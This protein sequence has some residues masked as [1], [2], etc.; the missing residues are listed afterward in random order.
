MLP[1]SPARMGDVQERCNIPI[2]TG[3]RF[4]TIFEFQQLLENK[5]CAYVRPD[6][7]PVWRPD[8]LQEGRSPRRGAARQGHSA[9]PTL[10]GQHCRLR[11]A[12]CLYP[13]LCPAGIYWRVGTTQERTPAAAPPAGAWL[14]DRPGGPGSRHRAAGKK[15][16]GSTHRWTRFSIRRSGMTAPCRTGSIAQGK[17]TKMAVSVCDSSVQV[18]PVQGFV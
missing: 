13:Q 8:R 11:A 3:E 10:T 1:D 4:T 15:R 9:Q 5:G 18:G 16:L 7:L 6:R 2:A 17:V 12:R 14:S